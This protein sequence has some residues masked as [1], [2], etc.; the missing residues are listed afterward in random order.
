MLGDKIG[1]FPILY[2]EVNPDYFCTLLREKA[3]F[4]SFDFLWWNRYNS[5]DSEH[6]VQDFSVALRWTHTETNST[7]STN[8]LL[9]TVRDFSVKDIQPN[10]IDHFEK[11]KS[12]K[13]KLQL[14]NL[15]SVTIELNL[16]F[17]E[18]VLFFCAVFHFYECL[19]YWILPL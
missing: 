2:V 3:W 10:L 4:L 17:L 11:Y 18:N 5:F 13:T 9:K 1:I 7:V 19:V 8:A 14:E 6:K 16:H 15:P 12:T